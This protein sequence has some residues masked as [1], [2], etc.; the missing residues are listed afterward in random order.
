MSAASARHPLDH[1]QGIDLQRPASTD[2]SSNSHDGGA[3]RP[4]SYRSWRSQRLA[5]RPA[6]QHGSQ[7]D[8]LEVARAPGSHAVKSHPAFPATAAPGL[9]GGRRRRLQQARRSPP[10]SRC[11]R[12]PEPPSA[13]TV[14]RRP[15]D[16]R[17]P[18]DAGADPP[19]VRP[20]RHRQRWPAH[21]GRRPAPGD[22]AAQLRGHGPEQGRRPD[23][24]PNTSRLRAVGALAP[25]RSPAYRPAGCVRQGQRLNWA[26]CPETRMNAPTDLSHLVPDIQLRDV[27]HG[28]ARCT[29]G[30]LR[31]PV[32]HRAGGA[33]AAR[34]R[35]VVVPGAA[36]GRR[37]VRR[38]HAGRGRRREAGEPVSR[39]R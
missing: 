33:R 27:P 16:S 5:A 13:A 30:T 8:P 17:G 28:A 35:R 38:K 32:F 11:P 25:G 34:P 10:R 29:Q 37:G 24:A 2:R 23:S 14:P 19:I 18:L 36:A 12:A 1:A 9:R 21:P 26:A 15:A 4:W 20:G 7:A 31:R 22:P 6:A 39:C 3:V